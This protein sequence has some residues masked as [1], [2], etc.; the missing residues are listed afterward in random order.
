MYF[1]GNSVPGFD[2]HFLF[3]LAGIPRMNFSALHQNSPVCSTL[4]KNAIYL[5]V[6]RVNIFVGRFGLATGFH[7]MGENSHK[8]ILWIIRPREKPNNMPL[9][10]I[11]KNHDY[12][13]V[14]W[15]VYDLHILKIAE[16]LLSKLFT[17]NFTQNYVE[18]TCRVNVPFT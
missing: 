1:P 5:G 6:K 8:I 4:I 12:Q 9:S 18:C 3:S 2:F 11:N 7:S 13:H 14:P 15:P 16:W 17:L 10:F